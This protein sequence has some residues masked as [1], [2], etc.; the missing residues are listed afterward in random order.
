MR[1]QDK[2]L[3]HYPNLF[4]LGKTGTKEQWQLHFLSGITL[5]D[6]LAIFGLNLCVFP[7]A[8]KIVFYQLKFT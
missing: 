4:A 8:L 6:S 7:Q 3:R 5:R 1:F 2:S